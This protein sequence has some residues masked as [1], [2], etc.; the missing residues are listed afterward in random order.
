MC[1]EPRA[2]VDKALYT[3]QLPSPC[4]G[5]VSPLQG[6]GRGRGRSSL[7][8]VWERPYRP[9]GTRQSD[10]SVGVS[11][12]G[13]SGDG[14]WQGRGSRS[15]WLVDGRPVPVFS[16]GVPLGVGVLTSSH[17][18][19][20]R[21]DEGPP[22]RPPLTPW[23]PRQPPPGAGGAPSECG[24]D[25]GQRGMGPRQPRATPCDLLSRGYDQRQELLKR[26]GLDG[27]VQ[28]LRP[29]RPACA[30]PSQARCP[31]RP[32]GRVDS[33]DRGSCLGACFCPTPAGIPRETPPGAWGVLQ[34]PC[35]LLGDI[36]N[37][38]SQFSSESGHQPGF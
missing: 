29:A 4:Q 12:G 30:K 18:D 26:L 21:L 27:H 20:V 28:C 25:A 33:L 11:A 13:W 31:R 34:A 35:R 38:T 2:R 17:E 19:A 9:A 7:P 16:L 24:G 3:F 14:S 36:V 6:C 15:A 8:V 32:G 10:S 22:T 1:R 23:P 5:H 37:R